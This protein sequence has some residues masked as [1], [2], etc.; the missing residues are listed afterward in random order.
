M[1]RLQ[2]IHTN[3][4]IVRVVFSSNKNYLGV[5]ISQ[6][7]I[8]LYDITDFKE[9][10]QFKIRGKI[11]DFSISNNGQKIAL[12]YNKSL[13]KNDKWLDKTSIGIF[14]L[15][16]N[17]ITES[18]Q[19][20]RAI[21]VEFVEEDF[22]MIGFEENLR[23][24]IVKFTP[25]LSET[26]EVLIPANE[27][28]P[29]DTKYYP[30]KNWLIS[31]NVWLTIWDLKTQEQV[32]NIDKVNLECDK[33]GADI[34]ECVD[35]DVTTDLNKILISHWGTDRG[36]SPKTVYIDLM[37]NKVINWYFAGTDSM[38]SLSISYDNYYAIG[39]TKEFTKIIELDTGDVVWEEKNLLKRAIVYYFHPTESK[40]IAV[41]NRKIEILEYDSLKKRHQA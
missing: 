11:Y 21:S 36:K 22:V 16:T 6:N 23:G 5:C 12:I 19:I 27:D 39:S 37:R 24:R 26:D 9:V 29:W 41:K 4:N 1:K 25:E 33:Y 20:P 17:K 14:E 31:L 10:G 34:W 35:F 8:I 40:I 3:G 28:Q 13:N 15:S 7:K 2:E 38:N 18:I 32:W 30:D